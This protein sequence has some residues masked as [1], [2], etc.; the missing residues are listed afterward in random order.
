MKEPKR[1]LDADGSAPPRVRELLMSA[2]PTRKMTQLELAQSTVQVAQI[3]ATPVGVLPGVLAKKIVMAILG[4]GGAVALVVAP[5][6][7]Q[8]VPL[9]LRVRAPIER[10]A[11]TVEAVRSNVPAP[12]EPAKRS[13]RPTEEMEARATPAASRPAPLPKK[14]ARG[15]VTKKVAPPMPSPPVSAEPVMEDSITREIVML[16]EA[17]RLMATSPSEALGRVEAHAREFPAGRLAAE[18][19]FLAIDTLLRLGRKNEA[20]ARA[21]A[22][23]ERSSGSPYEVRVRRKLDEMR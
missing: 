10:V 9:V 6:V 5:R 23:L 20:R 19:E 21:E 7:G 2:E 16:E 14:P 22:L 12:E 1:W 18:R 13:E 4:I 3:A 15:S 17:R 11:A 8:D